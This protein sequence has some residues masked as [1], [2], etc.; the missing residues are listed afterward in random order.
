MLNKGRFR[1]GW[2]AKAAAFHF[3]DKAPAGGKLY[4]LFQKHV[5]K[6]HPRRMSPTA[7]TGRLQCAHMDALASSL[8]DLSAV[9]LIELGAGWDLYANL[10]YYCRGIER[11]FAIDISALSRAHLVNDVIRHLQAEPPPRAIRIPEHLLDEESFR[12]QLESLY[13]IHYLAPYDARKL[14]LP[15]GS[16]DAIL[17]TSV[18]EHI[19]AAALTAILPQCRRVLRQS[20]MMRHTIDYTD[21][22]AHSD[23]SISLHN[24][25][26]FSDRAWRRYNP[27]IHYQNRLRT[28]R[29]LKLFE[30]A[31]FAV[32]QFE[33]HLG[34]RS[35]LDGLQFDKAFADMTEEERQTLWAT[36]TLVP[37]SSD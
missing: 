7:E 14:D 31:G 22:Y 34:D 17:S 25:M 29:Y 9:T 26:R 10:L 15:S 24:M 20:G 1:I 19:P 30:D 3:F 37:R 2:K 13:G 12:E 32:K 33:P 11:Q 18:F 4:Y 28:G 35:E 5:T 6:S 16:V 8:G 21:H 36:F 23:P 27:P